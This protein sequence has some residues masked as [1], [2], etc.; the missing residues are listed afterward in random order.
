MANT[1]RALLQRILDVLEEIRDRLPTPEPQVTLVV[2][3]QDCICAEHKTTGGGV[4]YGWWCP[5]HGQMY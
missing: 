4:S 1:E 3:P 5:V 2:P